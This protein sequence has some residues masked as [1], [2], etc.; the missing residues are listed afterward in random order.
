M[1]TRRKLSDDEKSVNRLRRSFEKNPFYGT[2]ATWLQ[3]RNH[4]RFTA[5]GAN[6]YRH[7]AMEALIGA[8][9]YP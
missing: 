5:E 9:T 4:F 3:A 2:Y 7:A 8:R 6:A 1:T